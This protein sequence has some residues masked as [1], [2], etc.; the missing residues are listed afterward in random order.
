M[1]DTPGASERMTDTPA[2]SNPPVSQKEMPVIWVT[3]M[4][5]RKTGSPVISGF[6]TTARPVVIMEMGTWKKL[7][8][9]HPTLA[10]ERFNVGS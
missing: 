4:P 6:G 2:S 1:S 10:T 5:F 8:A 9:D 3:H 7:C